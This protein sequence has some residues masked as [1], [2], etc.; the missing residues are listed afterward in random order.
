MVGQPELSAVVMCFNE[1]RVIGRCLD[2]L[3]F[4]DEI[5]VVDDCST[6]GTWEMLQERD[7]VRAFQ[8]RHTTFAAQRQYGK[9]RAT[10]RWILTMDADEY[11]TP[12]LAKAVRAA[13]SRS[14]APDVFEIR[15]R[16]PYP[17]TL[18]GEFWTKHP[19]LVRAEKCR[20]VVTDNPHSPL[21]LTGLRVEVLEGAYLEHEPLPDVA[22]MLRKNVNR[23]LIVAAL[24]RSRGRRGG[25][26]SLASSSLGRFFKYWIREGAW[27]YGADGL[28]FAAACGFEAFAKQAFLVE[29][30]EKPLESMQDGGPGS[31]PAGTTF[32]SGSK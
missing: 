15:R 31:Y 20:W 5:V 27:R 21:D 23:S 26:V 6:D 19:R 1:K 18:R 12:E 10:G 30:Q 25:L 9:D 2:A 24:D 22:T 4:C 28:I 29:R 14:D 7:G 11:V 32:V 16:N 17:A 8:H 3:A 13:I